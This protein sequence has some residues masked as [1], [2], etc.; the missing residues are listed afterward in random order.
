MYW[1]AMVQPYEVGERVKVSETAHQGKLGTITTVSP[2][3]VF[4]GEDAM[5]SVTFDGEDEVSAETFSYWQL[6]PEEA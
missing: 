2:E 4:N 1:N 5:Y 6:E 3:G